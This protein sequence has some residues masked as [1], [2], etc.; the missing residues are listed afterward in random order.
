MSR[1]MLVLMLLLAAPEAL[2]QTRG[3]KPAWSRTMTKAM[4]LYTTRD[5]Y[6]TSIEL[7]KVID[8]STGDSKEARQRAEFWMGKTLYH[9]QFY[10]TSLSY[11]HRISQ[12]GL[13]HRFYFASLKWLASLSR[14]LPESSG[15]LK[16]IGKYKRSHFDVPALRKV[17]WECYYLLG[18]HKYRQGVFAEA[19]KLLSAVPTTSHFYTKA[20]IMEAVTHVRLLKAKPAAAAYKA[21]LR[22]VQQASKKTPLLRSHEAL[23]NISLARLFYSIKQYDMAIKYFG[24]VPAR[25][26]YRPAAD[27]EVC[28]AHF[29]KGDRARALAGLRAIKAS[30]VRL[31]PEAHILEAAIHFQRK[32]YK[33]CARSLKDFSRHKRIHK[34]LEA[35]LKRYR[36][37]P[38][39]LY[40]HVQKLRGKKGQLTGAERMMRAALGDRSIKKAFDFV[41]ELERELKAVHLKDPAWK[42]K[43]I[44]GVVLQ[45]LTLQKSLAQNDAGQLMLQWFKREARN[46]Q[47]LG[48]RGDKIKAALK[49]KSTP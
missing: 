36:T 10:A 26:T 35:V 23:A 3:K 9:V 15:Y 18:R 39:S 27:F 5:Y 14:K 16:L 8:G 43:P 22:H 29:L 20:K 42:S 1:L 46:L 24:K 32:K 25:S 44:A 34:Q 4:K 28:W 19:I 17:R 13:K 41:E 47:T 31:V 7:H 48:K 6:S 38:A 37:G 21:V 12:T 11:F 40:D 45:D 2:A 33:A 49:K 30:K